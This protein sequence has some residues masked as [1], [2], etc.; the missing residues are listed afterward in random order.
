MKSRVGQGRQSQLKETV[1]SREAPEV[2]HNK[3]NYKNKTSKPCLVSQQ[4]LNLGFV[5]SG[6][7]ASE[8]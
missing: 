5:T 7:Q 3:A 4:T 6:N 1:N 2:R 8:P